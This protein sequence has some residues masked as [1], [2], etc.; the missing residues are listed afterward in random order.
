MSAKKVNTN[1]HPRNSIVENPFWTWLANRRKLV[2]IV[3][4]PAVSFRLPVRRA[5]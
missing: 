4:S 2:R 3:E 5:A 1:I